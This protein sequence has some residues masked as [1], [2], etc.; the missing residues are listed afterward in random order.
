MEQKKE[1]LSVIKKGL[2]FL[3]KKA[4]N[5]PNTKTN[6]FCLKDDKNKIKLGGNGLSLLAFGRYTL[7]TKDY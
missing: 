5:C 2:K 3:K 7:I 4:I 1:Y 6:A